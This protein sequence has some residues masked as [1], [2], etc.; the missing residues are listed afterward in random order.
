MAG[1]SAILPPFVALVP[2]REVKHKKGGEEPEKLSQ[3][4]ILV[5]FS[6]HPRVFFLVAKLNDIWPI[7]Y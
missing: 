6:H 3:V 2:R 1:H 5:L 4:D 7:Y